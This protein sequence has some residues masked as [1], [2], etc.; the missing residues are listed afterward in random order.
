MDLNTKHS[1]LL[2]T[3]LLHS[4]SMNRQK[5]YYSASGILMNNMITKDKFV[6]KLTRM[7]KTFGAKS[8]SQNNSKLI[9]KSQRNSLLFKFLF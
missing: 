6:E 5:L 9:I 4:L 2:W 1:E 7:S 8:K 3:F